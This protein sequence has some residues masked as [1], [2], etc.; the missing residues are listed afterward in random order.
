MREITL[1]ERLKTVAGFLPEASRF[2]DI[3]SDHAYL[4]CYVCMKD[5]YATAIA[6]EVNEGPY[7][8]AVNTVKTMN[9]ENRISVR[10]GNGLQ[11]IE[12]KEVKQVVIAGMGGSLIASILESGKEKLAEVESLVLQPNVDAKA[13]RVWLEHNSYKL[14]SEKIVEEGRHIY[15]V[16]FAEKKEIEIAMTEKE[17]LFGPYL[18]QEK[19]LPFKKKWTRELKNTE[20][21]LREMKRAKEVNQEKVA[22]YEKEKQ[23]MEEVIDVD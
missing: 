6:G 23:W 14:V 11:V 21:I 19:S 22:R 8:S 15:E 20:R 7:L 9:L 4:P 13:V 1:S 10:K 17:L 18:L 3:G 2:V 16:L 12:P 5:K